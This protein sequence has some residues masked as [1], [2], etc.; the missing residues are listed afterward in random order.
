MFIDWPVERKSRPG[1]E[2]ATQYSESLAP[3]NYSTDF[4]FQKSKKNL[5][6]CLLNLFTSN[7]RKSTESITAHKVCLFFFSNIELK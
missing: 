6:F 5:F 7:D 4:L 3:F 2:Q 1:G